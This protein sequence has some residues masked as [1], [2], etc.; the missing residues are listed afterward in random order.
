MDRGYCDASLSFCARCSATFFQKPMGTDRQC[1]VAVEDDG[2]ENMLH[3]VIRSDERVLEFD[4][5]EDLQE[6]LSLEGWEFL[7]DFDPALFRT[8]AA[9]RWRAIGRLSTEH[10]HK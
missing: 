4:L 2:H 6:G 5:T 10:S 9:D 1:V 7:S 3:F 8:G